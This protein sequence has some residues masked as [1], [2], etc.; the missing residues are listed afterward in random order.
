MRLRLCALIAVALLVACGGRSPTAPSQSSPTESGPGGVPPGGTTPVPA[1]STGLHLTVSPVDIDSIVYITPMGA[2]APWGHTLPTDHVYFYHYDGQGLAPPVPV[3]A[4]AGGRVKFINNGRIDVQVDAVFSYWIGPLTFA[5]GIVAGA[6]IEAGT[7]L[8]TH[9]TFPALDFAVLRSTLSL[10]FVNPRRYSVDTLSAD[11]PMRYFEGPIRSPI[12]AKV[13]RSGGEIDGRLNYDVADTLSG[14]WYAEDLP[15]E[16]SGRGGEQYYG[17]RKLSFAR[18][19]FSPDQ[20]RV[21][22]GGLGM[23]GLYGTAN[24]APAF[25]NVTPS[26]GL[27]VYR[28]MAVG[29][30]QSPPTNLQHGWLLV[31]LLD[32]ERLRVEAVP[33][34]VFGTGVNAGPAPAAFT[35]RAELYLR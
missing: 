33:L 12:L 30:R 16:I 10:P 9:A 6:T 27:V 32:S 28:M 5:E 25:T 2:M 18:D 15:V 31:Q 14:N 3:Y 21:S 4:P 7:L 26:S 35:S 8:G 11:G 22:I 17:V 24:D 29:F 19:V 23:T 1:I 34:Q 13:L 20:P